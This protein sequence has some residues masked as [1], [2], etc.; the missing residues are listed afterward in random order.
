LAAKNGWGISGAQL[1]GCW[2]LFDNESDDDVH[3]EGLK[4]EVIAFTAGEFSN[5]D[6]IHNSKL[7]ARY[8]ISYGGEYYDEE[9]KVILI[10]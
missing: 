5:E 2:R 1:A 3:E 9:E 8:M 7:Y 10:G 6:L 4:L